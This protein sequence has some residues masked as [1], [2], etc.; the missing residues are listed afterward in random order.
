M[1]YAVKVLSKRKMSE[2]DMAAMETEITI[3]RQIDHPNII[4]LL[5]VFEDDRHWCLV[6][7]LMTGGELFDLILKR[8]QFSEIEARKATISMIDAIQY[9]HEQGIL[10]RDIK[11]ENLLIANAELGIDSLKIADF[12]LARQLESESLA[13]TTCGT[14]G[15][16][17]PEVLR[18]EKYGKEC[19]YWSIGVV[20]FILLSGTPPFYEE[21]NFALFEQIKKCDYDFDAETWANVSS[22]AKDFVSKILVPDPKVRL[23]FTQMMEHPWMKKDLDKKSQLAINKTQLNKYMSVRKEKSARKIVGDEE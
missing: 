16:V 22:E 1:R 6:M 7:E 21:E 14:P 23:N 17:A 20:T 5:D 12:G 13:S 10:H 15:Y 9:C 11:P 18:Q 2:E 4:K 19:D 3:M 8:D